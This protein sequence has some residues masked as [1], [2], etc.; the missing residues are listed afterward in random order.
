[1]AKIGEHSITNRLL[2]FIS[3]DG[4]I[5]VPKDELVRV[6]IPLRNF[7]SYTNLETNDDIVLSNLEWVKDGVYVD[8]NADIGLAD[9]SYDVR[10]LS[11][12]YSNNNQVGNLSNNAVAKF[13]VITKP[14]EYYTWHEFYTGGNTAAWTTGNGAGNDIRFRG[15]MTFNQDADGM[16]FTGQNPWSSW[17]KVE[18]LAFTRGSKTKLKWVFTRPTGQMMIGIGSDATNEA[19]GQQRR[20][21]EVQ[22]YFNNANNFWGIYGNNGTIGTLGQFRI[23]AIVNNYNVFAFLFEDDGTRGGRWALFGLNDTALPSDA[24]FD[25]TEWDNES[26]IIEQGIVKGTLNPDELNLFPFICPR[27]GGAQRF[28][29]CKL[30]F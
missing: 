4:A 18:R 29:A 21:A 23:D 22:A 28:I 12:A 16:F 13:Q 24:G 3:E 14:A 1:M 30:T 8:V 15:L 2:P 26:N 9:G 19:S 11:G 27:S 10:I 25:P 6:F 7:D 17:V 5:T 20:Q